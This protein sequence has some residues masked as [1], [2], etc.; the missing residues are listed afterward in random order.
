MS[1]TKNIRFPNHLFPGGL[2]FV[3]SDVGFTGFVSVLPISIGAMSDTGLSA[4]ML[5]S[6]LDCCGMVSMWKYLKA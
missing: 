4:S 1:K 6:E 5:S 2:G 3:G